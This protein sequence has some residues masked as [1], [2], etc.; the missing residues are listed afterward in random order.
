MKNN[1]RKHF[2]LAHGSY[3]HSTRSARNHTFR[4]SPLHVYFSFASYHI[5][6]SFL[7][8]EVFERTEIDRRSFVHL[9]CFMPFLSASFDFLSPPLNPFDSA[10]TPV[11]LL[12]FYC[13]TLDKIPATTSLTK[14]AEFLSSKCLICIEST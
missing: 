13:Y 14:G 3:L 12:F 8:F 10:S 1:F 5:R 11:F 2:Y 4:T 7:F 6:N 9:I